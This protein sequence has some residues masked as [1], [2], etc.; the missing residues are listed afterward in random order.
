MSSDEPKAIGFLLEWLPNPGHRFE[1]LRPALHAIEESISHQSDQ[2]A[3]RAQAEFRRLGIPADEASN[4]LAVIHHETEQLLSRMLR[5]G[6]LV[7]M[8]SLFESSIKDL[9][10]YVQAKRS[11]EF[12]FKIRRGKNLLTAADEFFRAALNT[13]PFLTQ[14]DRRRLD[15]LRRFRN[16][17]AHADGSFD[18]V[19]N[20]LVQSG[21]VHGFC[22]IGDSHEF[23]VP[24][25]E[26][27]RS[28]LE[29]LQRVSQS[30][31]DNVFERTP[32]DKGAAD[33]LG[34]GD[35]PTGLPSSAPHSKR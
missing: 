35:D 3:L 24:S 22:L 4:E 17:F 12:E 27:V 16:S 18:D 25:A 6:F 9:G 32:C 30:L 33:F 26:Y 2:R 1:A 34:R 31:A 5:S 29:L 11:L 28:S 13:D 7:S 10:Q 23:A 21:F 15:L 14:D 19:P 8:W 20:E